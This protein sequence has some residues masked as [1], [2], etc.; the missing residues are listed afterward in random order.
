MCSIL[1]PE[2]IFER[3]QLG[4]RIHLQEAYDKLL[5][6]WIAERHYLKSTPCGARLRLW[7]LDQRREIIGA[8][9]WGKPL[10]RMLNQ[11]KILVLT[12]MFFIEEVTICDRVDA[13][14]L[15]REYIKKYFPEVRLLKSYSSQN[16]GD[17]CGDVFDADGWCPYGLTTGG[18]WKRKGRENR[19]DR[20]TSR[21]IRWVRSP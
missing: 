13:L 4:K 6:R 7:I 20:D 17:K 16:T 3:E 2:F 1:Q 14:C 11:K 8:M 12:R 15:S 18:S 19:K 10:S 21:K 9:M 5:D